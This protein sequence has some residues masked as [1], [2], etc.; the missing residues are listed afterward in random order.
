MID[1]NAASNLQ[2]KLMS[3]EVKAIMS[4]VEMLHSHS[5]NEQLELAVAEIESLINAYTTRGVLDE[6]Q[7]EEIEMSMNYIIQNHPARKDYQ[8]SEDFDNMLEDTAVG[9]NDF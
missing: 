3:S 2:N 9:S 5:T 6:G 1:Q 4:K 7:V 8:S